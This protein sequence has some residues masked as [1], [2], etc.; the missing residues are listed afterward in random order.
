MAVHNGVVSV[1]VEASTLT[2]PGNVQ[3]Y[4][5][6]DWGLGASPVAPSAIITVGS[7]PD[8]LTFAPDG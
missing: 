4:N 8:M 2:D 1:A 3:L 5:A 6:A 7:L